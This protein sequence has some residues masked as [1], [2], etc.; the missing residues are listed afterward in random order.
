M[1]QA[2]INGLTLPEKLMLQ[3]ALQMAL[4]ILKAMKNNIDNLT[5]EDLE[6]CYRILV[7]FERILGEFEF[8]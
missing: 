2:N 8:E 3:Y 5:E 6:S 4:E 1:I 7:N